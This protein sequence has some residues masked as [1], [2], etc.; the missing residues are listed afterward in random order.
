MIKMREETRMIEQTEVVS[1]KVYIAEDGTQFEDEKMCHEYE[2]Q[3]SYLKHKEAWAEK[4]QKQVAENEK[5]KEIIL[6]Y[7]VEGEKYILTDML[8][9]ILPLLNFL[10]KRMTNQRLMQ[11][12]RQMVVADNTLC[13]IEEHRQAY[14]VKI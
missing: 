6:A 8:Y 9:E 4:H 7:M 10:R 12:T 11:I 14:F 13:R 3:L 2:L 1:R 5:V